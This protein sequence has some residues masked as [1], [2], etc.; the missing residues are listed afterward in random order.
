MT[1]TKKGVSGVSAPAVLP[2][3]LIAQPAGFCRPHKKVQDLS[4]KVTH[5]VQV[6]LNKMTNVLIATL[7]WDSKNRYVQEKVSSVENSQ[8]RDGRTCSKKHKY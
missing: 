6:L 2:G 5:L 3:G 4:K 7:P 8:R 1:G